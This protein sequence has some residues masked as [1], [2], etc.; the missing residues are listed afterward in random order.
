MEELTTVVEQASKT[1]VTVMRIIVWVVGAA[2]IT[3]CLFKYFRGKKK[4]KE[5]REAEA[6]A[7]RQ[8]ANS[9]EEDF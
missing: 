5:K 6:E 8:N 7:A 2:I 1:N 3:F 4:L 9:E